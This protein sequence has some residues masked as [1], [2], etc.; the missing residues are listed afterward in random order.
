M[1]SKR[2]NIRTKRASSADEA[3]EEE[4]ILKD[5]LEDVKLLQK[6]R[7]RM[8]GMGA[9]A[10]ATGNTKATRQVV[11][12]TADED[13]DGNELLD[14]YV[15][16]KAVVTAEENPHMQRYVEEELARRLGRKRPGEELDMADPLVRQRLEEEELYRVPEE[17]KSRMQQDVVIPGLNTSITEVPVPLDHRLRNIEQTE[18]MKRTLLAAGGGSGA[19][20]KPSTGAVLAAAAAAGKKAGPVK[21]NKPQMPDT[22]IRRS[23][24]VP[25]FGK[26]EHKRKPTDE[27]VRAKRWVSERGSKAQVRSDTQGRR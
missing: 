11:E 25:M 12:D 8:P 18:A 2:R 6:Q 4:E 26:Q 24:C 23:L 15:K 22:E 13:D 17:L 7:R 20:G 3:A 1:S 19:G 5:N 16:A 10:L 9:S 14:S 27:E 21:D